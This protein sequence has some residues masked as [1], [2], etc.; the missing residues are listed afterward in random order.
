M[1]LIEAV[2]VTLMLTLN[3]YLTVAITLEAAFKNSL[4]KFRKFSSEI[5]AVEFRYSEIIVFGIHTNFTYDFET[6]DI[7]KRDS[8]SLKFYLFLDPSFSW[9]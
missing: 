7:V 3:V 8:G 1:T 4:S 5:S 6:Y 2:S 9:A